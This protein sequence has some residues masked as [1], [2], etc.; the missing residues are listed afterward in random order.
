MKGKKKYDRYDKYDK[1]DVKCVKDVNNTSDS[2]SDEVYQISDDEEINRVY[3]SLEVNGW[4]VLFMSDSGA[5]V[6]VIPI[7]WL[8]QNGL[9]HSMQKNK[10]SISS[11]GGKKV[12]ALGIVPVEIKNPV[13]GLIIQ[14]NVTVV[15][16][17][18]EPIL[19]CNSCNRLKLLTFSDQF[20]SKISAID[21][22]FQEEAVRKIKDSNV[23]E[24]VRCIL[25]EF[26]D[27][28]E[29]RVGQFEGELILEVVADAV[30]VQQTIRSIPFALEEK[31]NKEIDRMIR[32]DIIEKGPSS[33]LNSYVI[34]RKPKGDLWIC[35]DPKP[36]NKVL[37][38]NYHCQIPSLE[39]VI[40]KFSNHKVIKFSKLDVRSGFCHCKLNEL[41]KEVTTFGTPLGNYHYKR[42]PMGIAPASKAFQEIMIEQFSGLQ[43]VDVIQDDCLVD[44]FGKDEDRAMANHNKNLRNYLLRCREKGIKINL[45]KCQFLT[46]E[47]SYMGHLLT[48]S[49]LK[50]N[51]EKVRAI[52]EFPIP[53]DLYHLRRFLGMVKYLSRFDHTLT[54]K[55][56]PL[57]RLTRKNQ[58]FQWAEVQQKAFD[59][60]KK[61]IINT[62]ALSYYDVTKPVVIQ[63]DMSDV[64]VGAVLMQ[65]GKPVSFASRVWDDCERGYAPI[66]KE[67]KAIVF[68][69]EK[70]NDYCFGRHVTVESDH[71]PLETINK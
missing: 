60:I 53:C 36:L 30:P 40:H 13:T 41:S 71:K 2:D 43:D 26:S 17:E 52:V 62:P 23:D 22:E 57:N 56:E 51:S 67:M 25:L 42:L 24:T 16:S 3:A 50:P 29:D 1:R 5:T 47:V 31:F 54:T 34:E 61:A 66:E 28:F 35:L 45:K 44:G 58:L 68:G 18:A 8:K 37:L 15:D 7:N 59:D 46:K 65:E 4:D 10:R 19:G 9:E 32:D 49:G 55:C 64:G 27:V 6:D 11:Y 70:F 63:T 33:W 39:S 69:L 14:S 38:K 21:V 20:H 48:N 12:D